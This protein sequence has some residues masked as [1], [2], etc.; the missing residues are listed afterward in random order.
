[1]T[2][3]WLCRHDAIFREIR[4]SAR[5]VPQVSLLLYICPC[6]PGS[7]RCFESS[8]NPSFRKSEASSY[9]V[10]IKR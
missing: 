1:M 9:D 4:D 10:A 7:D 3:C 2:E 8:P 5:S 6:Q